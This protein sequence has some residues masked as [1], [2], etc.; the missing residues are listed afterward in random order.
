MSLSFWSFALNSSLTGMA[1]HPEY[2]PCEVA[3]EPQGYRADTIEQLSL[4]LG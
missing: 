1:Y 4:G 2:P 3:L